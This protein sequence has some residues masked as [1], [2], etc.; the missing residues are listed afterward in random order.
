MVAVFA[1]RG[2][3]LDQPLG[4]D[5]GRR[6]AEHMG[7]RPARGTHQHPA[8]GSRRRYALQNRG[9]GGAELAKDLKCV[10]HVTRCLQEPSRYVLISN[11]CHENM[12]ALAVGGWF[13]WLASFGA[14][15]EPK[16]RPEGPPADYDHASSF[17]D[18]LQGNII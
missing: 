18:A 14:N 6:R 12:P 16:R 10:R 15:G 3:V 7:R 11:Q 17:G 9:A 2:L 1:G 13:K 8:D 5:A 4:A